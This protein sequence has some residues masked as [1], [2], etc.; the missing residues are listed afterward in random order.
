[1]LKR[2]SS[3][4]S[5]KN[6]PSQPAISSLN[7]REL[8]EGLKENRKNA[9]GL[10]GNKRLSLGNLRKSKS[11][12][13]ADDGIRQVE[14]LKSLNMKRRSTGCLRR[15]SVISSTSAATTTV[16]TTK[17]WRSPGHY[18]IPNVFGIDCFL[19]PEPNLIPQVAMLRTVNV[20]KHISKHPWRPA[21]LCSE[22]PQLPPLVRTG[23]RFEKKIRKSL[24][25]S[26]QVSSLDPRNKYDGFQEIGT[27]V[28]GSVVRA[29]HKYKKNV[30]LA[31]KRCRL[32]S[33]KE[34]KAS[35]IRE[36]F[37]MSTGHINL[38]R[39]KE[40]SLW[41]QEVW[42]AMDLQ[43]CSVFA[44][45]CQRGIPEHYV[46]YI[47]CE[48]LRGLS[49]L[50]SKSFIHRDIKCENL[51]IGWNGEIKLADFGLA[52]KSNRRNRDRLGTSKW[53]APE[54]IREQ[55]YDEKIDM[56]SLGITIIEM[57]DR[58]PPHYLIRDEME[59]FK[60]ILIESSPTF[61]Y[62]F[63]SMYMRGL[64]A[65]LLDEQPS[66]RPSAVDV[67]QEIEAHVE[68]KLLQRSTTSELSRFV[69]HVLSQ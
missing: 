32:D 36:L 50:H 68:S 63:P 2:K 34:Y 27:G 24:P 3:F 66:T 59:L 31:I 62:S 29:R 10:L 13:T 55:L 17:V 57:M 23:N 9:L 69:N 5:Y 65:W 14:L 47:V 61:T 20:Q 48:T 41:K 16:L 18:E 6:N 58:V 11:L 7:G 37:I 53:M 4:N 39:L 33:D 19:K 52:T 25:S 26:V 22:I 35:I 54:V 12:T 21:G 40:V 8:I 1:M 44:V 42:M 51:L 49:Y 30:Y 46:V 38:I 56:W 67:L 45:L 28:N 15:S 43:R 64:V 60:T